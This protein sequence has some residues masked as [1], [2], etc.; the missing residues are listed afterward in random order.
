M[1][2]K[3]KADYLFEVSWEVCNKVGGIYTVI[4][5]KAESMQK[6]YGNGY[7]LIGPYFPEKCRGIFD[8]DVPPQNLKK[9]FERLQKEG[10]VCHY[11]TW[12]IKGSPK[13]ILI[14][15]AGYTVKTNDTKRNL[16]DNYKI[17]SLSTGYYDFDE[18][19]VWA[20]SAGRFLHEFRKE[21][22]KNIISAHFHEWLAGA[23]LLYIASNKI[24]IGTIFTTHATA[25]GRA[26]ANSGQ[27]MYSLLG[28]IDPDGESKKLGVYAK[29]QLERASAQNSDVFTTVSE[30]TSM[31]AENILGRKPD[32]LLPNGLDSS[33]FQTIE[34]L[35]IRHSLLKSKII[36]FIIYYF[37]PYYNF[38]LDNILIYFLAGRHEFHNK[39]IDLFIDSLALLNNRLKKE[40]SKKTIVAFLWVPGNIHGIKPE[41]LENRRHYEDINDSINDELKKIEHRIVHSLLTK[42]KI[43]QKSLLG[44]SV[45]EEME[46]K[47]GKFAKPGKLPPLSTHDLY[48]EDKEDILRSLRS[49]GMSNS[50][51][52]NVKIVYYPI[53]LTGADGL[54]DLSYNECMIGSHL[55]IFPSYYE[56][57]GYTTL[58]SA[59][60]GVS[61][62]TTDLSGYGRFIGP[63][64]AENS[65]GIYVTKREGKKY[66][67][68]VKEMAD[69][70]HRFAGLSASERVNNK[71]NARKTA[72]MTGW[73][74]LI[75]NYIQAHN[76]AAK[77]AAAR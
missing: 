67:E 23:G 26:M 53:Y 5:S 56:P 71:I 27:E 37:F 13:A 72:E 16:W 18:P 58:E 63:H 2:V 75:K 20:D 12:L 3:K 50:S 64:L 44:E 36:D 39:G 10:I 31:E 11:G 8:E 55:G 76:L 6:S 47:V 73:G 68:S 45:M 62:I 7:F 69:V 35:H 60:L 70:M 54:L 65:P 59:A 43:S 74:L 41:L 1:S 9:V 46:V 61:A 40:K 33:K 51:R 32:F 17:D 28:S 25:L 66:D 24:R 48:D 19:V 57:W 49:S 4:V 38:D 30:I 34:Q 21:Y 42:S 77:K 22:K 52:D 15:F 14:D 29:H